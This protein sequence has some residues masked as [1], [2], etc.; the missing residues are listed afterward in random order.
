MPPKSSI[1]KTF[2]HFLRGGKHSP[3]KMIL[4]VSPHGKRSVP[5][6]KRTSKHL[7]SLVPTN[8]PPKFGPPRCL[9]Y[10]LEGGELGGELGP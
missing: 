6:N 7:A 8:A 10:S 4:L 2:W 3:G 1:K 5:P 9:T